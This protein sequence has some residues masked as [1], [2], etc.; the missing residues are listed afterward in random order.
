MYL[1]NPSRVIGRYCNYDTRWDT[2]W[3]MD[4][5]TLTILCLS[6]ANDYISVSA[7]L[8]SGSSLL[9]AY[10]MYNEHKGGSIL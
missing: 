8:E 2:S 5:F 6:V 1:A 4:V 7:F 9:A 3:N 10:R